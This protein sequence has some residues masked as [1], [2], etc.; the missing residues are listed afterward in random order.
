MGKEGRRGTERDKGEE[1]REEGRGRKGREWK[2]EE[3]KQ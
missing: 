2:R 1:K 3:R